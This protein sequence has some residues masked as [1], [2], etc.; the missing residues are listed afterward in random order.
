MSEFFGDTHMI[1]ERDLSKRDVLHILAPSVSSQ[2]RVFMGYHH[3]REVSHGSD[4]IHHM[5]TFQ[6]VNLEILW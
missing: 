4:T 6:R 1:L 5:F 2:A 3:I